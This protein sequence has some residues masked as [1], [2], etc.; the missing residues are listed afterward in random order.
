M[1]KHDNILVLGDFNIHV[2]CPTQT[3]VNDF[4]ET[5]ESFNLTQAV[6][7]PT[8]QKGH[9]LDLIL[10][11]GLSPENVMTK[12]I[13]VSDHKAV[14]FNVFLTQTPPTPGTPVLRRVFNSMSASKFSELFLT[15]SSTAFNSHFS[16]EELL[17][18]FKH[19]CTSILDSIA[20]FR[21][22]TATITP[23]PWLN[24]YTQEL[25][26]DYGRKER[27]WKK[28]GLQVFYDI[29][30]EALSTYQKAVKEAKT[31]FFSSLILTNY[32]NPKVLFKVINSFTNPYPCHF[33][34]P[35]QETCERF[36]NF[37]N[38][39]VLEIRKQIVPPDQVIHFNRDINNY[40]KSFKPVS[41]SFLTETIFQ[42]K[43]TTCSLDFIP[44]KFLK[45]V[46]DT[47]GPSILSIINSSL[48][49]G[50]VPP[51][52][53]HAVVQPLLK[54]PN[55]D[56]CVLSNFRPISNLPFLSKVLEKVVSY[57]LLAF[58]C[59]N[60]IFEKFQ[61]GFRAF[62]STETALLK[63]SNDLFLAADRGE[64][65]ILILLDLSAAFDTVDH[66]ILIDRLRNWV[67]I[68]DT[69]L[70]W[71]Y[72]YLLDRTFAVSIGNFI[73]SKS[74]VTCG[75]PQ[76]SILG[77]V[78]FSVYMLP[79]GHIIQR[80]N[81]SFHCY[82]DDT[83]IYLPLR[84]ADPGGLAA[85]F[86]C[87]KDINSWMAQ[88][89]LHLNNS[90]TEIILFGSPHT[91]SQLQHHLGPLSANIKSSARNLGVTLDSNL[92]FDPHIKQ[93]VQS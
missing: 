40:L 24:E 10:S 14:L 85:V 74:P 79:L 46:I 69:A 50:T 43:P 88:N 59:H 82:A 58:M 36:L 47:V 19:S 91:F 51:A 42:M 64:S 5:F 28:T 68:R 38:N 76:G 73:S 66:A 27:K 57:Q 80:H 16:A 44:T 77:P 55:L 12:D 53:K 83:Q 11:S 34:D 52:F 41:L 4:T 26:R 63:V 48:A 84:P 22:K 32:S 54:K 18:L 15:T 13:C 6:H 31:S 49:E 25:K 71:F 29:W 70:G 65:S 78:L 81:V 3:L 61:S 9:T 21:E 92:T 45:D 33:T 56:P 72:S 23:Q 86:D 20:P 37:F 93:V 39:K 35:S 87:L 30:K 67:G 60:N 62:H 17:S 75:V 2:C 90:K 8:H 89:F 1:P 7:V